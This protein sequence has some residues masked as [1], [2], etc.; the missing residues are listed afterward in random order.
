MDQ[1]QFGLPEQAPVRYEDLIAAQSLD[2]FSEILKPCDLC[3]E[4]PFACMHSNWGFTDGRCPVHIG[5]TLDGRGR[6]AMCDL[7]E[8]RNG[9]LARRVRTNWGYTLQGR[10]ADA[11]VASLRRSATGPLP[12]AHRIEEEHFDYE[13]EAQNEHRW[14]LAGL[15]FA[16]ATFTAL[17]AIGLISVITIVLG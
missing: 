2:I 13:V 11:F 3:G 17:A 9:P 16:S 4:Y 1:M 15:L 7:D 10:E 6:C 12:M 14:L 8:H 5:T